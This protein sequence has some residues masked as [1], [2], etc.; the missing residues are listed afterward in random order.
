MPPLRLTAALLPLVFAAIA[1]AVPVQPAWTLKNVSFLGFTE[2]GEVITRPFYPGSG[3]AP[4]LERR[5]PR[6][7][8]REGLIV[9]PEAGNDLGRLSFAPD[10]QTFAWLNKAAD[11][12]TVRMPQKRWTSSSP[13]LSGTQALTFSPDGRTLAAMNVFGYVQLWDVRKGERRATLLLHSQPRS[14][15]FHPS[16]P[17][18][19]V[20]ETWSEAGSVTLWN[21]DTGQKVLTV[22]GLKGTVRPFQFAPDGR[23]LVKQG[24]SVGFLELGL[25]RLGQGDWGLSWGLGPG[26]IPTYTEP[27]PPG[28]QARLCARGVRAVSFSADGSRVLLNIARTPQN[29]PASLLYDTKTGSL[30][31][32]FDTP[33]AFAVLAPDGRTLILNTFRGEV[34]GAPLP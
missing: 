18:L 12:L 14:L 13:G 17:L 1:G 23:L 6:T 26:A 31:K 8:E 33:G 3:D 9:F 34:Q 20:N 24:F 5:R 22:P 7:G 28:L 10:L 11:T 4:Q 2:K 19:A 25:D 16:R 30:L 29:V 21:T 27:C 32:T 15:T